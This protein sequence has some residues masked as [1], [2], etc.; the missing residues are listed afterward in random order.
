[1]TLFLPNVCRRLSVFASVCSP[2]FRKS[3]ENLDCRTLSYVVLSSPRTILGLWARRRPWMP[4]ESRQ[5]PR[6]RMPVF[7]FFW[8][9]Q[10]IR[11]QPPQCWVVGACQGLSMAA[12]FNVLVGAVCFFWISDPL[13]RRC[14]IFVSS[15]QMSTHL[16]SSP[17]SVK[18]TP[19]ALIYSSRSPK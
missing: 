4:W 14:K 12:N 7:R 18:S 6:K 8:L 2:C 17:Q 13:W 19:E 9:S 1:M 3:Q 5:K 10:G 11:R 16:N 15:V